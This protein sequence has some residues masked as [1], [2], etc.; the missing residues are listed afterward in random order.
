M[1]DISD[2]TRQRRGAQ[3]AMK[4]ER[5][6]RHLPNVLQ[7]MRV[8]TEEGLKVT[9]IAGHTPLVENHSFDQEMTEEDLEW[10]EQKF[11]EHAIRRGLR[12]NYALVTG[13]TGK[14]DIVT[15]MDHPDSA[16]SAAFRAEFLRTGPDDSDVYLTGGI[17]GIKVCYQHT[18]HLKPG[19]SVLS[20]RDL[21]IKVEIKSRKDWVLGPG[22]VDPHFGERVMIHGPG[23]L[24]GGYRESA[25]RLL[26][27]R[28]PMPSRLVMTLKSARR[29]RRPKS[30]SRGRGNS[31]LWR[32]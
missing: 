16:A 5:A 26:A 6:M 20:I 23:A 1:F 7:F 30:R 25:I 9:P 32:G 14:I 2:E 29:Q 10:L 12:P 18:P 15:V 8:A 19:T 22:C 28:R 11:I 21:R 4:R 3:Q 27:E 24:E 31:G 13:R 17:Y